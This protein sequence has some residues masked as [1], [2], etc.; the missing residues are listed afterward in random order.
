M[1][2]I[3]QL[4]VETDIAV[5]KNQY[6]EMLL[7][8][9]SILNLTRTVS[10]CIVVE[11]YESAETLLSEGSV[12]FAVKGRDRFKLQNLTCNCGV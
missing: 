3:Y 10:G 8:K 12:N 7:E 11:Q 1:D 6:P 5:D 9:A 2:C 4:T